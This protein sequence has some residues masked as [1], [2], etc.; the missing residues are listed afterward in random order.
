[1]DPSFGGGF[2]GGFVNSAVNSAVDFAFGGGSGNP[3]PKF[4]GEGPLDLLMS[5]NIEAL[6]VTSGRSD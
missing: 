6:L 5:G 1:M 4:G 2:G 3:L